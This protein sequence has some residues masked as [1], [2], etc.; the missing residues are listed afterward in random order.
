MEQLG[1]R[2]RRGSPGGVGDLRRLYN[3]VLPQTSHRP[4]ILIDGGMTSGRQHRTC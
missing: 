1:E 3:D 2:S 4:G